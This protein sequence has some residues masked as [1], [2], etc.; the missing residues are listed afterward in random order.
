MAKHYV[1]ADLHLGHANVILYEEIRAIKLANLMRIPVE[2]VKELAAKKDPFLLRTHNEMIIDAWNRVVK[3]ED[4][5]FFLGDFCLTMNKEAIRNW[6]AMLNGRKRI[7]M[8]NH[9][10][11]KPAFYIECG[12]EMATP[13][14]SLYNQ[15]I[16]LSHA[17]MPQELVPK[18]YINFF[19]HVHSNPSYSW[20]RGVCVSVEQLEDFHPIAIDQHIGDW[21]ELC[22]ERHNYQKFA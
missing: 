10:M 6:T 7:I 14:P 22:P 1:V 12:F 20:E 11:R 17:P 5:V 19:G 2:E 9:D 8:G 15:H 16:W 3:P 13:Y 4:I 18:G 21:S